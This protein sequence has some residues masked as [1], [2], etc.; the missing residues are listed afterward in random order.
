MQKETIR[1]ELMQKVLQEKSVRQ[2]IKILLDEGYSYEIIQT[3]LKCSSKTISLV[4]KMIKSDEL[5]VPVKPGPKIKITKDIQ[6]V[7]LSE[8]FSN[9]SMNLRSLSF[10]L[11]E[12]QNINVSKSS[13]DT[14]L[15]NNHCWYGP[16]IQEPNLTEEQ[17]RLRMNFA[18]SLLT[19]Q[20]NPEKI[21][22]SDESRFELDAHHPG[23]WH[24][25]KKYNPLCVIKRSKYSPAL[26]IWGM[27]AKNFK[28]DLIFVEKSMNQDF[29]Q[30]KI[31]ESDIIPSAVRE[32]G[33]DFIFQQDGA[34]SHTT[35]LSI[36][37]IRKI[38]RIMLIW[39]PN[40][41]DLNIIEMIWSIIKFRVDQVQPKNIEE[42]RAVIADVW[43]NLQYS[44]INGLNE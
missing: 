22:F 18:Y 11:K 20:I 40:S 30:E 34:T 39:P 38:T 25:L 14:V 44:T 3:A 37:K 12:T 4:N 19:D 31:I 2:R 15:L 24:H 17:K 29:Y 13:I 42:L 16:M 28:S 10:H 41:P 21:G 1:P 8:N 32:I 33:D 27:V 23:V 5:I 9:P 36:A 43:E 26:M 7:I 6:N 35:V